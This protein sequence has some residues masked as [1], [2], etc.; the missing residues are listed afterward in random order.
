M[1]N[2]AICPSELTNGG[3]IATFYGNKNDP[4]GT[5]RLA[6]RL[7]AQLGLTQTGDFWKNHGG[8]IFLFRFDLM[9][10]TQCLQVV[11]NDSPPWTEAYRQLNQA[12]DNAYLQHIWGYTLVGKA[13]LMAGSTINLDKISLDKLSGHLEPL[14]HLSREPRQPIAHSQLKFGHLWLMEIP[15]SGEGLKAAML[16]FAL[17]PTEHQADELESEILLNGP[18]TFLFP[19]L[20][21]HKG[22][23]QIRQ[24]QQNPSF[25]NIKKKLALMR[26]NAASL[27]RGIRP[28]AFGIRNE[29]GQISYLTENYGDIVGETGPQLHKW[30]I[31]LAKQDENFPAYWKPSARRG[32]QIIHLDQPK[33]VFEYHQRKIKVGLRSLELLMVEAE[34]AQATTQAAIEATR[35][36]TELRREKWQGRFNLIL[37]AIG[38]GLTT[39]Q[40]IDSELA[41]ALPT[42]LGL[43]QATT[44]FA[45][46]GVKMVVMFILAVTISA[47]WQGISLILKRP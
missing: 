5:T 16:Y 43:A 45:Q 32:Q 2:H 1:T 46:L 27:L 6:E 33:D 9:N 17:S 38:I 8:T 42:L 23:H 20:I 11:L 30:Y 24:Y 18:H 21:A 35:T 26:G 3:L 14:G 41:K 47:I 15:E 34:N 25:D 19:D 39:A 40:I 10:D 44:P 13:A 36:A 12:V 4:N 31:T 7:I 29:Q 37:A 28:T 22:Y